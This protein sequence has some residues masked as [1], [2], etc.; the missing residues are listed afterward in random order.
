MC[1]SNIGVI[2]DI[3][4][5]EL[6]NHFDNISLDEYVVM[7]NHIHMIITIKNNSM[8]NN[9]SV[10]GTGHAL[11]LHE[12]KPNKKPIGQKRFQNIGCK[13]L[14]SIVGSYKSA[15]TK[16][17]NRLQ[18]PFAWQTR[19]YEHIIRDEKDYMRIKE[20]I[21]TNERS[22][23]EDRFKKPDTTPLETNYSQRV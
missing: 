22:W 20:Y 2:A 1:L 16:H 23:D 12:D 11:S 18:F 15:T 13:S 8:T 19:F 6:P 14:S 5:H 9:N 17:V 4:L 7:P 3:L 21:I 10:V